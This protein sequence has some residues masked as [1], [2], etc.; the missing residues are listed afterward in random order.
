MIHSLYARLAL[1]LTGLLLLVGILFAVLT[2][3]A[4]RHALVEV[5]QALNQDLARNLVADRNLVRDGRLDR[6][7]LAQTFHDYM[8]INPSIEIYLLDAG[9]RI[10]A[11]SADPGQVKRNRVSLAPIHRFL[12]GGAAFPLLGDD[13]RSHDRRK[14]FSV[15]PLPA[16][17]APDG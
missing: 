15:T 1:T 7:A 8:V 6:D 9:G 14:T 5:Q 11:Y 10:L 2:V 17:D 12:G 16:A 13:P 4:T 3:A